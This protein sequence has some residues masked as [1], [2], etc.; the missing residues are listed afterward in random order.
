M[1]AKK[2]KELRELSLEELEE[3]VTLMKNELAKEKT[4]ISSGTRA[5]NPGKIKKIR[6]EIA[7]TLTIINQ[8]NKL[9]EQKKGG[10]KKNE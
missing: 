10:K 8:K 5:E 4:Q 6:R 3:K 7:R 9:K 1:T 2:A